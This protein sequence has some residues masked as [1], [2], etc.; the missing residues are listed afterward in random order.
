[1]STNDNRAA[2][3]WTDKPR[4]RT[5]PPMLRPHEAHANTD[6]QAQ[7]REDAHAPAPAPQQPDYTSAPQDP[8][9]RAPEILS[10]SD[11]EAPEAESNPMAAVRD[12]LM[13]YKTERDRER[14]ADESKVLPAETSRRWHK[15]S[16]GQRP[17]DPSPPETGELRLAAVSR[18][19]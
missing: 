14:A 5:P 2:R 4:A 1:M 10:F 7:P 15:R 11:P 18:K 17:P 6:A 8:H 13:G 9:E 16:Q 3:A 19:R 12:A